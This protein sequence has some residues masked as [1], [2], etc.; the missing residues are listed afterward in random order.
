L[1]EQLSR[2]PYCRLFAYIQIMKTVKIKK[3][4]VAFATT[5]FHV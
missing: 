5:L 3:R 1:L 4:V 2:N